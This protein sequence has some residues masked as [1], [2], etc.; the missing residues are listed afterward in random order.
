MRYQH[1][2]VIVFI[3]TLLFAACSGEQQAKQSRAIPEGTWEPL[4]NL[5]LSEYGLYASFDAN[6]RYLA[7]I[8]MYENQV[9]VYDLNADSLAHQI[10]IPREEGPGEAERIFSLAI[11]PNNNVFITRPNDPRVPRLNATQFEGFETVQL[12]EIPARIKGIGDDLVALTLNVPDKL[13][14]RLPTDGGPEIALGRDELD[15]DDVFG[16]NPFLQAGHITASDEHAVFS[17]QY[18]P[19]HVVYTLESNA[20]NQTITYEDVSDVR[21]NAS[22]AQSES[23]MRA[24]VPP[25]EVD[26]LLHNTAGVPSEPTRLAK[27]LEGEGGR[28]GSYSL[29][30]L[31]IYD[32]TANEILNSIALP[33]KGKQVVSNSSDLFLYS[34]ENYT[35]YRY[36]PERE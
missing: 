2:S 9:F 35:V 10:S 18:M 19:M 11:N 13:M 21:S 22:S 12:A 32:W 17:A 7:W 30:N 36:L 3:V 28:N 33:A 34:E 16:P 29:D 5:E 27:L 8:E 6:D 15:V 4:P 14:V 1:I 31:Y 20:H 24:V 25:G 23:G 26:L